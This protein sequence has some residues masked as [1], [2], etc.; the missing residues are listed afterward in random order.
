MCLVSVGRS[1]T[2]DLLETVEMMEASTAAFLASDTEKDN[3]V[4]STMNGWLEV[5]YDWADRHRVCWAK[6]CCETTSV[7]SNADLNRILQ[8]EC[9]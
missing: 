1:D 9:A 7:Q 4:I 6:R 3:Q 8:R 2:L 5:I